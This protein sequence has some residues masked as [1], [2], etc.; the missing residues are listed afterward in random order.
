MYLE[1][2]L[3]LIFAV[4]IAAACCSCTIYSS[5]SEQAAETAEDF[6][7]HFFNYEFSEAARLVTNDSRRWINFFA[8]NIDTATVNLIR[9]QDEAAAVSVDNVEL[10]TDTSATAHVTVTNFVWNSEIDSRPEVIAK[11]TFTLPMVKTGGKWSVRM[12][13]LR[14]NGTQSRD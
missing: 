2:F 11:A 9:E 8:T 1:R 13:N 12:D 14:Q 10:H 6:G 3:R 7:N 5:D 4:S